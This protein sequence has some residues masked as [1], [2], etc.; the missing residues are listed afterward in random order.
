M[1]SYISIYIYLSL[2]ISIYIYTYAIIVTLCSGGVWAQVLNIHGKR[3]RH[4]HAHITEFAHRLR[5]VH[6][7]DTTTRGGVGGG[8]W[9]DAASRRLGLLTLVLAI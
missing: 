8:V 1:Y 4:T 9:D 2:Y 6:L 7:L 3:I 5:I